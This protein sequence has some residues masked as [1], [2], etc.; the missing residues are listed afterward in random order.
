M[1]PS[2]QLTIPSTITVTSPLIHSDE[3]VEVMQRFRRE[4]FLIDGE[5]LDIPVYSGNAI[6]GML[7]RAAA[8]RVCE[9]LGI[10]DRSLPL[11]SFYLLFCGGYLEGSSNS[12]PTERVEHLRSTLPLLSLLGCSWGSRIIPGHLEVWRGEPVCQELA[13]TPTHRD[14][15]AYADGSAPS[16]FDLLTE[17]SY[18]RR[19]DRADELGEEESS[20]VQMRYSHEALV[21]GTRLLHG[22]VLRR[23]DPLIVGCLAD[24]MATCTQWSTLGGR[25]AIGHGRFRWSWE[26]WA[27]EQSAE[28]DG[29]REHLLAK[30]GEIRTLLEIE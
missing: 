2:A 15:A 13:L 30:T 17:V 20:P 3:R 18:T 11:R 21:P 7:R 19:D 22:A 24:A 29:Y 26:E 16:V 28:V 4:P 23:R 5:V 25:S 27:Q 12:Y 8:L 10:E 9:A 6:R 14:E 1:L